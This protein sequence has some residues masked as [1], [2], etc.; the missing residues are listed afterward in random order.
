MTFSI[1]LTL[2]HF[3]EGW[4]ALLSKAFN[5]NVNEVTD[6]LPFNLFDA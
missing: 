4:S 1:L 2:N 5:K 6:R 3:S